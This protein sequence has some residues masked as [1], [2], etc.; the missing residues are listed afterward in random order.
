MLISCISS[1][2]YKQKNN[3]YRSQLGVG[4]VNKYL[5]DVQIFKGGFRNN[6]NFDKRKAGIYHWYVRSHEEILLMTEYFKY[7]C[8]SHKSNL[9]FL[10]DEYYKLCDLKAFKEDNIY[11]V[12][13]LLF[14]KKWKDRID[15]RKKV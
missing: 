14:T 13:W 4:V 8:K 9:F 15:E 6:I 2:L 7:K 1:S 5:I 11:Y 12:I 3:N 10:V